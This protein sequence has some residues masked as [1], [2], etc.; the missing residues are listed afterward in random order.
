VT[1]ELSKILQAL[2]LYVPTAALLTT[3]AAFHAPIDVPVTISN[4]GLL[5]GVLHQSFQPEP[6]QGCNDSLKWF[7]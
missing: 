5:S 7:C 6:V 3:T 4:K 2:Q 1:S